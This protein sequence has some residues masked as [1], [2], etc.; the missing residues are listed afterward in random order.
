MFDVAVLILFMAW[1]MWLMCWA[2]KELQ[3]RDGSE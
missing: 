3:W 2:H 1:I